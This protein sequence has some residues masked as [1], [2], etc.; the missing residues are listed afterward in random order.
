MERILTGAII[1]IVIFFAYK[2]LV[3]DPKYVRSAQKRCTVCGSTIPYTARV[4]P[5]C[6]RNPGVDFRSEA[7]VS[8]HLN[9]LVFILTSGVCAV[10]LLLAL[11]AALLS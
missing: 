1:L 5:Y 3:K 10:S 11:A 7:R 6:R 9:K 2:L 4:C 8:F